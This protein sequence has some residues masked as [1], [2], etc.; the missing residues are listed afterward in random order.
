MGWTRGRAR[1]PTSA[2]EFVTI[3]GH[4]GKVIT[5]RIRCG[6]SENKWPHYNEYKYLV[7]RSGKKV[8]TIYLGKA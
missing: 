2:G 7:V 5:K 1:K 3:Q 6:G 4:R 8:K